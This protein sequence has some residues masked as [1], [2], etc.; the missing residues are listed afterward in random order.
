MFVCIYE[1]FGCVYIQKHICISLKAFRVG[2]T[3]LK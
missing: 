1:F 3:F 2:I